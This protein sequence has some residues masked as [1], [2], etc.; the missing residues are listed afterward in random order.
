MSIAHQLSNAGL[1]VIEDTRAKHRKCDSDIIILRQKY[2]D[3]DDILET[4]AQVASDFPEPMVLILSTGQV[5]VMANEGM[6]YIAIQG[7]EG[8]LN[9]VQTNALSIVTEVLT[10]HFGLETPKKRSKSKPSPEPLE[11]VAEETAPTPQDTPEVALE[12][13]TDTNGGIA[14]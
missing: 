10:N 4:I 7:K 6:G 9:E 3:N 5:I 2:Y 14:E 1:F 11:P 13:E 8:E 12:S